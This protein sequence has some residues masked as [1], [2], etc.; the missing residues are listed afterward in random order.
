MALSP[1]TLHEK[2]CAFSNKPLFF[3]MSQ[4]DEETPYLFASCENKFWYDAK[5]LIQHL[6]EQNTPSKIHIFALFHSGVFFLTT[7]EPKFLNPLFFK[8]T[9]QFI[10]EFQND[11]LIISALSYHY[12]ASKE[13]YQLN[14]DFFYQTQ[15]FIPYE[16]IPRLTRL[17][18]KM[19]LQEN[20]QEERKK[21]LGYLMIAASRGDAVSANSAAQI[22]L[23]KA[24]GMT[25]QQIDGEVVAL[26]ENVNKDQIDHETLLELG[27]IYLEREEKQKALNLFHYLAEKGDAKAC[28]E[29]AK[30]LPKGESEEEPYRWFLKA[31]EQDPPH[32][33][34]A[35][36]AALILKKRNNPYE[37]KLME[38]LF[39]KS[40][41][42]NL[43]IEKANTSKSNSINREDEGSQA[44]PLQ[45]VT[46]N[47]STTQH[48]K[49]M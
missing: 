4:R 41:L 12:R 5:T 1:I 19:F 34:A 38:D 24:K 22:F 28:Y 7:S 42:A 39:S 30:L 33:L 40:L 25:P 9:R 43:K 10:T 35:L 29:Y 31:A 21:G 3:L 17:F 8:I 15:G 49:D 44:R 32:R 13:G 6:N 20:S 48:S 45:S 27:R 26:L 46:K 47:T 36:E 18:G 37:K 11:D 16:G 14:H 23:K 2:V